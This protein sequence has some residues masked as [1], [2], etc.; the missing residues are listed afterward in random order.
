MTKTKRIVNAYNEYVKLIDVEAEA[1]EPDAIE[2]LRKAFTDAVI[3]TSDLVF[4]QKQMRAKIIEEGVPRRWLGHARPRHRILAG[5]NARTAP[6]IPISLQFP[7][8]CPGTLAAKRA[9][10]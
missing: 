7:L 10:G 8:C 5:T 2:A 9:F 1:P 3:D 4:S 6:K